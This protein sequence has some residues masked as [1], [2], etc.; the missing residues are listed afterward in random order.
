MSETG[1]ERKGRNESDLEMEQ[2]IEEK[3]WIDEGVF[4]FKG[5]TFMLQLMFYIL[6]SETEDDRG[7]MT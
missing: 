5:Q 4:H 3:R 7:T 1:Q 6:C 2:N